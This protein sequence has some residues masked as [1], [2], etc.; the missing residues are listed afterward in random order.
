MSEWIDIEKRLPDKREQYI[1]YSEDYG[2]V[3]C[4][5]WHEGRWVDINDAGEPSLTEY[6]D[7]VTHW[8]PLP[9][10]PKP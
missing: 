3:T 9:E 8:M 1:V 5:I 6:G 2:M 4:L 7:C 10:P